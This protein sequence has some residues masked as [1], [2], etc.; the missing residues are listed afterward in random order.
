MLA[1]SLFINHE[2]AERIHS[3]LETQERLELILSR[4]DPHQR[5]ELILLQAGNLAPQLLGYCL[6]PMDTGRLL[7]EITHFHLA[8][9]PQHQHLSARQLENVPARRY[10]A[11]SPRRLECLGPLETRSVRASQPVEQQPMPRRQTCSLMGPLRGG[12]YLPTHPERQW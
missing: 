7:L 1:L 11:N 2:R 9:F 6:S 8:C 5:L 4:L 3:A 12:L 10:T